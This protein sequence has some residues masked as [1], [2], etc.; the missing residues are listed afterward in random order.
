M[1][2][3]YDPEIYWDK[4]AEYIN[5]RSN[6]KT[7]AG[8]DEPY[9]R[10]KRALF[11]KWLD[12]I[13]FSNKSVL[14]VGSGPG[15]NLKYLSDKNCREIAGVD[16][17]SKMIEISKRLLK[18]TNISLYKIDGAELPFG[19]NKFDIIFT[20]TVLQHNTKEA[21]VKALIKNICRVAKNEIIIF[22]RIEKKIKGHQSNIG[23]PVEY[24]SSL[25]EENDFTLIETKFLK[26][27]ASY[28]ICGIIRK[29]FNRK[30]RK[31]GETISR[32][33]YFFETITLPITKLLDKIIPSKRDLGMLRF[34]RHI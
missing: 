25:F 31:E 26:I 3:D 5:M 15:G 13:D 19:N 28:Y 2:I 21:Q 1:P 17:S 8:D 12:K 16:I 30:E 22:E 32:I 11:L 34:K 14:E 18:E 27:Q 4:V 33:S 29:L 9:Y 10:Y 24:Y 23:R 7:I 6:V 20:S